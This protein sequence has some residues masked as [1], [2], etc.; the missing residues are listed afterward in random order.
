MATIFVSGFI[1]VAISIIDWPSYECDP[2][3]SLF[4]RFF[5]GL[6]R[7][8]TGL[9]VL[10]EFFFFSIFISPRATGKTEEVQPTFE[11]ILIFSLIAFK[12]PV[13]KILQAKELRR[14]SVFGRASTRVF[15][16]SSLISSAFLVVEAFGS[17]CGAVF[18]SIIG[19]GLIRVIGSR[20]ILV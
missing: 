18:L 6:C 10:M 12:K 19:L 17:T 5:S 16:L 15:I 1:F 20:R 13:R 4:G 3:K 2:Q 7:K 9:I 8:K 11:I 14:L